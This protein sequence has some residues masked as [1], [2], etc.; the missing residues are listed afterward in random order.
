MNEEGEVDRGTSR[1]WMASRKHD[2]TL[3]PISHR[4]FMAEAAD[5]ELLVVRLR[6]ALA[7]VRGD[8]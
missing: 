5:V 6:A 7:R 8:P 4:V 1:A 3:V 2:G